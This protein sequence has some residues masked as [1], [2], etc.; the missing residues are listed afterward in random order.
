MQWCGGAT[1]QAGC[2]Q[3]GSGGA[4]ILKFGRSGAA[5]GGSQPTGWPEYWVTTSG[6]A[7]SDPPTQVCY[8]D[9]QR[10]DNL[11]R[12]KLRAVF[13]KSPLLLQMV[14]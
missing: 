8:K 4:N 9:V 11:G 3:A 2:W 10:E 1:R 7:H 13:S 14:E 6:G 12:V 5:H